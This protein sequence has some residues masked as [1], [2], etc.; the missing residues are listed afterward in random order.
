LAFPTNDFKQELETNEEIQSFVQES[1]PQTNFPV[2]GT[3]ELASNRVYQHL[4]QQMPGTSVKHNF[5]KYLVNREGVAQKF[6]VK[7]QSPLS[8]AND[9]EALLR[10]T[11]R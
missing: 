4:Y 2:F 3:T 6:Y 8:F 7:K 10:E 5:Y 1:Y 9:I 11:S